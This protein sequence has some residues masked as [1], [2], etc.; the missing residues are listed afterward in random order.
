M[1]LLAW[2]MM[3]VIG[4]LA[5]STYGQGRVPWTVLSTI[6]G[7][8]PPPNGGNQQ[9]TCVVADIDKDGRNDFFIADR[10]LAPSV[11]LYRRLPDG[12]VKYVIESTRLMIE[13]GGDSADID[14]DG[15]LDLALG[16]DNSGDK[17]WWW[18]NPF[19]NLDPSVP[20]ARHLIK[21]KTGKMHHDQRFG[22]FDGD[23]HLEF[24]TW[25]NDAHRLEIYEIPSDPTLLWNRVAAI[26]LTGEGMDVVDVDLNGKEDILAGGYWIRHEQDTTYSSHPIDPAYNFVRII[27]AQFIPGERPEIIMNSGDGDGPLNFYRYLEGVWSKSTLINFVIHGHTLEAGDIDGDGHLDFFA[28]EMGH[29]GA[30][31]NALAWIGWGDGA[32]GFTLE[33]ISQGICNHMSRL[34]DLDGD[35]DLDIL[36]KPYSLGAPRVDVLL[37]N[38]T[39]QP[40][41]LTNWV[42]HLIED[43][44]PNRA[45]FIEAGDLRGWRQGSGRWGLVVG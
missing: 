25:V 44:L 23:G 10:S 39:T 34:T 27:G 37:N 26:P 13:A 45:I 33:Q 28:A 42:T 19:P 7:D 22:D 3:A 43:S 2:T 16:E 36:M 8:L 32:G 41:S 31:T 5:V 38:G 21:Q 18:E 17:M 6:Y 1:Q 12:W 35:H 29:P 20:W 15:D 40:L 14:G 9:T 30:G 4:C 24:A 11:I